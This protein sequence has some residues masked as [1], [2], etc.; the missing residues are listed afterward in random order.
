MSAP[1]ILEIPFTMQFARPSSNLAEIDGHYDHA[2]Q[3]W[4]NRDISSVTTWSRSSTTG[5]VTSDP[6]EDKDD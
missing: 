1:S 5:I 4:S 2:T 6:D 3:Q